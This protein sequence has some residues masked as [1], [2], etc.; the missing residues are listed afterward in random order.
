MQKENTIINPCQ[1]YVELG[2][3]DVSR[4]DMPKLGISHFYEFF[5]GNKLLHE[6]KAV[7]DGS[8]DL[9]FNIGKSRVTTFISGTVFGVKKWE[10]G[11]VGLCFGV[12]FQPGQGILPRELS[13]DMLVNDD[14]EID[15]NLFGK[16]LTERIAMATDIKSRSMIFMEAYRDFVYGRPDL[17]DKEMINEYLVNR[18]TRANG[19]IS[20]NELQEETNY[21]ACYLRRVFKNYNSISPKQFARYI[22]FQTLLDKL[23]TNNTRYDELALDCGYFDEAHMMKEFKSYAGLTLEQYRKMQ[24]IIFCRFL[25]F[26]VISLR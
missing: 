14:L 15:G 6:L 3:D 13:M 11:D 23:N 16:N 25:N 12:R 26:Q 18:I 22:R 1:P 8:I 2:V 20:I 7:P 4:L 17:S 24:R 5:L 19:H 21:S 10:L 9:L